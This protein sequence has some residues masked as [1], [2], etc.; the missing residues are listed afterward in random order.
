MNH[1]I[2]R[3]VSVFFIFA[4]ILSACAGG[5][6]SSSK[7]PL[8]V[9]Y[10][11]WWSDFTLVIAKEKGFFDKYGVNVEPVYYENF[12]QV[13]TDLPEKKVDGGLL[14]I[15]DALVTSQTIDLKVV[16]VYDDGGNNTVMTLP[17]ITSVA[18][19]KGK[20]IGVLLGTSYELFVLHMLSSAGLTR[21]DVTLVNVDPAEVADGLSKGKITAGYVYS[22]EMAPGYRILF[23][24]SD[25][26][27]LFP[28]VITF[29]E[30]IVKSRP[31]DIRAFLK[32]WFEA[33]DYRQ[34]NPDEA[35]RIAAKYTG[36]SDDQIA[37]DDTL[38]LFTQQD[39]EVVFLPESAGGSF[40]LLQAAQL[41]ADFQTQ[42]GFMPNPVDLNTFLD[43]SFLK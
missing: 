18:E 3:I 8:R 12:P 37:I 9:E 13:Y 16:A 30:D 2:T 4:V 41:N 39:N 24:K 42:A 17:E 27:G 32:A 31:D 40:S 5:S 15:G 1:R 23:Q 14:A 11:L 6:S 38:K 43:S 19:L 29:R 28:D 22:P 10:T 25:A 36:L 7:E 35:R 33:V 20:S 21:D 34:Q 26:P